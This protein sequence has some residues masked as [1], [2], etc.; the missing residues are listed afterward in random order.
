LK[1]KKAFE[2]GFIISFEAVIAIIFFSLMLTSIS[3]PK[4]E[5]LKELIVLQQENDLLKIWSKNFPTENEIIN[6]TKEFFDNAKIIVNEKEILIGKKCFGNTV[7][8]QAEMFDKQLK[9]NKVELI[10][11]LNC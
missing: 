10:I 2:K 4:H 5:S 7:A 9:K 8:S 11:Y 3:F 1:N 6:D